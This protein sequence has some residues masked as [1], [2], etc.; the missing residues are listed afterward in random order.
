MSHQPSAVF[1]YTM[2]G[3]VALAAP[4]SGQDQ[5]ANLPPVKGSA[6]GVIPPC[7]T[8]SE[9]QQAV[10]KKTPDGAPVAGGQRVEGNVILPSAGG[11][12]SAAPTAQQD[13][14]ALRSPIDCPMAPNHPNS[15]QSGKG[16]GSGAQQ[17]QR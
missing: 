13:G 5:P 1:A 12:T 11:T 8:L 15:I 3:L 9:Q 6:S 4:C 2:F 7:P 17:P 16:G 10:G 14:E